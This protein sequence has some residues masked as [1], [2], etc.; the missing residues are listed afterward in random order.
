MDW[1]HRPQLKQRWIDSV[2]TQEWWY[3][4]IL[5]KKG[6]GRENIKDPNQRSCDCKYWG[7]EEVKFFGPGLFHPMWAGNPAQGNV[8]R[9]SK[10][11]CH[12]GGERIG[13]GLWLQGLKFFFYVFKL[14]HDS[15]F[16]STWGASSKAAGSQSFNFRKAY[17]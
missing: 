14:T 5:V 8:P 17:R 4:E 1:L 9:V 10:G 13:W 16:F 12:P 3:R 11:I 7:D 2:E 6:T 15:F